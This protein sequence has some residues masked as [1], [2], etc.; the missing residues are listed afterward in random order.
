MQTATRYHWRP[1]TEIARVAEALGLVPK[2]VE[3]LTR[4]LGIDRLSLHKHVYRLRR[5]YGIEVISTHDRDGT[6]YSVTATGLAVI[7]AIC[8]E[9]P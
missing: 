1:N 3:D 8:A 5:E 2:H 4:E 7:A 9:L 6:A